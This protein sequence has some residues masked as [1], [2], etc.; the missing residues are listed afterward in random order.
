VRLIDLRLSGFG[1]FADRTFAFDPGLVV[2]YGPNEAGKS[3]LASAIVATLY[4]AGRERDRWRPWSGARYGAT[5]RYE[6]GDGRAFEVQRDF[7]R[8]PKGVRVYDRDGNDVT[9]ATSQRRTVSPG[10]SHL[11]IPIEVFVNAACVRQGAVRIEGARAEVIGASLT[12]ALDGGPRD[13][14]ALGAVARLERAIADHVGAK[15]ATV[16][17]PLRALQ[18]RLDETVA[19]ATEVRAAHAALVLL[20]ATVDERAE[21]AAALADRLRDYEQRA[22]N[23]SAATLRDRLEAL[24]KNRADTSALLAQRSAFDD[25]AAFQR[26]GVSPFAAQFARWQALASVAAGAEADALAARLGPADL[27]ELEERRADGGALD[28]DAFAAL[29][30]LTADA[31]RQR[32]AATTASSA[33]AT[34]RSVADG[35]A[36][37]LGAVGSAAVLVAVAAIVLAVV[38]TWA[39]AIA[40]AVVA[41]ACAAWTLRGARKRRRAATEVTRRQTEVDVATAAERR[42]A[43]TAAAILKPLGVTSLDELER[44]RHRYRELVLAREAAARAHARALE[45]RR[46]ADEAAHLLDTMGDG[47]GLPPGGRD[48]RL[49]DAKRR[50]SRRITRDG[51]DLSLEMLR[52]QHHNALGD[53]D[54]V[55][56]ERELAALL[57]AGAVP[58]ALVGLSRRAFDAQR[59]ELQRAAHEAAVEASAAGGALR[60]AEERVGDLAALDETVA[61]LE[62]DAARL[63]DFERAVS[64]AR[65]TIDERAREAHQK[66]ARRLEDYSVGSFLRLTDG[67]YADLRVDPTTLAVRVRVPESGAIHD[68]ERLSTGTREQAFLIVRIAMARMFAEGSEVLPLLLDDPFAYWDAERL[69]R[70]LPLL[71]AA[72]AWAQV[73]VFTASADLA[74]SAASA[75]AQRIDLPAVASGAGLTPAG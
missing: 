47:L 71:A 6:L 65:A 66:F 3:T 2:V 31:Q 18:R 70:G 50:E 44:R 28:D 21:R 9:A 11:G 73:V 22:R 56:L 55:A 7:E 14:A 25:V 61:T 72:A 17:A 48:A 19:R 29:R 10:S 75:G 64:L 33:A 32:D 41:L 1:K 36:T 40:A 39:P 27:S 52:V 49:A 45:A 13:D 5:L 16:N 8:D 30:A 51:I 68:L 54:D 4:G 26:A 53:D 38:H 43:G 57:A 20:R 58:S 15:R 59:A 63:A 62:R 46:N 69:A 67:R 23:V 12:R 42:S 35:G 74:A 37:A 34:A 24:R 60:S